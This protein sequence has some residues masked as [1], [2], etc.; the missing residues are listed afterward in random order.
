MRADRT[1]EGRSRWRWQGTR[2]SNPQPPVLETGALPIE[3][4]PFGSA[5]ASSG[6]WPL[7]FASADLHEGCLGSSACESPATGDLGGDR[8]GTS[9]RSRRRCSDSANGGASAIFTRSTELQHLG[10]RT[11]EI[12]NVTQQF[13]LNRHCVGAQG[14]H[15]AQNAP[16]LDLLGLATQAARYVSRHGRTQQRCIIRRRSKQRTDI[17]ATHGLRQHELHRRPRS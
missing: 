12:Q 2:D 15:R 13:G 4:V 16:V 6:H 17:I 8:K 11:K 9:C 1:S 7:R 14:L 3:L 5:E 10:R